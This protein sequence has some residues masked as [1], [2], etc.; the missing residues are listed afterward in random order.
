MG[1]IKKMDDIN[2]NDAIKE[3][4]REL[5]KKVKELEEGFTQEKGD[6]KNKKK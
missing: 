3:D 1:D 6:Y 2:N 4:L 5:R